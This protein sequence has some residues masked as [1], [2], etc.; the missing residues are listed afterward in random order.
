MA[1]AQFPKGF[2]FKLPSANAPEYI[3]HKTLIHV[4]DAIEWLQTLDQE[5][6]SLDGKI[7]KNDKPYYQIDTWKSEQQETGHSTEQTEK[8]Q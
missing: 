1:D 2:F 7:S 3:K 4:N 8:P 6:V 5:W